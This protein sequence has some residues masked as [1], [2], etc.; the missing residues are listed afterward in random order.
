MS[1]LDGLDGILDGLDR[2]DEALSDGGII[3]TLYYACICTYT[4]T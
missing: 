4:Y 2:Q 3:H 1:M